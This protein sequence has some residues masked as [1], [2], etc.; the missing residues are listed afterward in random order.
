LAKFNENKL[1]TIGWQKAGFYKLNPALDPAKVVANA[2][3]ANVIMNSDAC[4]TK[5]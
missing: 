4:L 3:V 2:V 1:K 5:R